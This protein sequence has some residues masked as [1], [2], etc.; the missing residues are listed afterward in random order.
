MLLQSIPPL[1]WPPNPVLLA[2]FFLNNLWKCL[3]HFYHLCIPWRKVEELRVTSVASFIRHLQPKT[4]QFKW[5]LMT[6]NLQYQI[7]WGVKV[8]ST[9]RRQR[10]SHCPSWIAGLARCV[11]MLARQ[12]LGAEKVGRASN[13]TMM[14][15][16]RMHQTW[17]M[18]MERPQS[19][20]Q[21]ISGFFGYFSTAVLL[22]DFAQKEL[23][24]SSALSATCYSLI[25]I[26]AQILRIG[27][28][29]DCLKSCF[30]WENVSDHTILLDHTSWEQLRY[31][32]SPSC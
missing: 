10:P 1:D 30:F 13:K 22:A 11:L 23:H 3:K 25:G 5:T 2:M 18:L 31:Q 20:S 26:M 12:M 21:S 17:I 8:S 14:G 19:Q 28:D 29:W 27:R 32:F 9:C 4:P 6:G 24:L 16:A 15:Q 7:P